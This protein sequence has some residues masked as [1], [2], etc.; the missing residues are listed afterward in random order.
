MKT[1]THLR[2]YIAKFFL[3]CEMFQTKVTGT[4]KT[5]IL[6]SIILFPLKSCR[7]C[8]DVY[9]VRRPQMTVC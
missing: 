2:S 9:N 3:E 4:F 6:C 7:L 8:D 5:H 1:D